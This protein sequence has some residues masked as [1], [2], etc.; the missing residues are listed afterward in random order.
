MFSLTLG[1][2]EVLV[3]LPEDFREH[4]PIL[5]GR[6]QD[7]EGTPLIFLGFGYHDEEIE[8][9]WKLHNKGV[10]CEIIDSRPEDYPV[11]PRR[12]KQRIAQAKLMLV[13][14]LGNEAVTIEPGM[15]LIDLVEQQISGKQIV[16]PPDP[17]ALMAACRA[18]AIEYSTVCG[19]RQRFI[20]DA[21]KLENTRPWLLLEDLSELGQFLVVQFFILPSERSSPA[22]FSIVRQIFQQWVC[23]VN[24]GHPLTDRQRF[25]LEQLKESK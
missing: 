9:L 14:L 13:N 10:R 17:R 20:E 4:G 3:L 21:Q 11:R 6:A 12:K 7:F 18:L 23:Q 2:H 1:R 24:A 15:C 25:D 22:A 16:I 8:V 19:G 5:N